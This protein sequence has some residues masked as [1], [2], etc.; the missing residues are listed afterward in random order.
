MA[1]NLVGK[2][3][4]ERKCNWKLFVMP[5]GQVIL[6][7][8]KSTSEFL[9]QLCDGPISWK[10]KRQDVVTLSSTEAEYIAISFATQEIM[11]L[12][13]FFNELGYPLKG[14]TVKII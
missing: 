2:M 4:Q 10:N 11:W 7:H 12:R 6:N 14:P 9:I 13:S 3:Q 1:F 8:K 5:V